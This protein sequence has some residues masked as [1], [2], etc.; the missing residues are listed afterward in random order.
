[1]KDS[2]KRQ[3]KHGAMEAVRRV[4]AQLRRW[5]P[6]GVMVG[7]GSPIDEYDSYAPHIVSLLAAGATE[8]ELAAH[9]EHIQT[10]TMRLPADAPRDMKCAREILGWWRTRHEA[11][12]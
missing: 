12:S 5:D 4:E 1:M 3:H 8:S 11:R 6:I 2:A 9:L 7:E 10:V